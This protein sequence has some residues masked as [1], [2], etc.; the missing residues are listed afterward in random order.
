VRQALIRALSPLTLPLWPALWALE[1]LLKPRFGRIIPERIGHLAPNTE[2]F[3]RRRARGDLP[4]A[5]YV[6]FSSGPVAN[7]TLLDMFRRHVP[8]LEGLPS[9]VHTLATPWLQHT[10]FHVPVPFSSDE[11]DLFAE[12]PPM[13]ALTPEQEE[14]GRAEL[15][16]MGIGEKDWF[17][18]F[19]NRDT[20]YLKKTGP[21]DTDYS[22]HDFR[23]TTIGNYIPAARYVADQGGFAIRMGSAVDEPLPPEAAHP[24]IIDYARLH[25]SDFMDVY[26]QAKARF[27]LTSDT[28]LFQIANI[29]GVPCANPNAINLAWAGFNPQDV[30]IQKKWVDAATG[31]PL[32]Y[33]QVKAKGL[34]WC[35]DGNRFKELGLRREENTP[36]EILELT[37]ELNE[38]LTGA[39][40]PRPEDEEL[41]RSYRA[42]FSPGDKAYGFRSRMGADYLRRH[43]AWLLA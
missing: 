24:R 41:Q 30:F 25:R 35:L 14:R 28:G 36:E 13:L 42:L 15:A 4:K 5:G 21:R 19:F 9:K 7:R 26:L 3:L 11:W 17:V 6:L 38:R 33:A 8:I 40:K 32:P 27:V 18:P 22:Y 16:K 2:L 23:D 31:K 37:R 29:L 10:R 20:R 34:A 43:K 12:V 1:P 39:W